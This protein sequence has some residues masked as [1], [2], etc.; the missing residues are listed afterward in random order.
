MWPFTKKP[1]PAPAVLQTPVLDLSR[2]DELAEKPPR[3]GV[4]ASNMPR[5][6]E[7]IQHPGWGLTAQRIRNAF[8]LAE[9][10]YPQ[11]QCDVFA[12]AIERDGKLRSLIRSRI[13]AVG[14]KPWV[15][16]AGGDDPADAAA[17]KSLEQALRR[18]KNTSRTWKHLLTSV[19]Q[20]F[21][22]T[23]IDWDHRDGL[24]VPVHFANV[25]H[26]RFRF[27]P[28]TEEPRLRTADNLID[29]VALTPGKWIFAQ[30]EDQDILRSGLMRTAIWWT[31]LKSLSVRDWQIFCSRFGLPFVIATYSDKG[32]EELIAQLKN[33]VLAF[34]QQGGAVFSEDGKIEVKEPASMSSGNGGGVHPGLVALC[35]SELSILISGATLTSGEGTSAGSYALGQ[36]HQDQ[37]FNLTMDDAEMLAGWFQAEVG[38]PFVRFNGLKARAPRLKMRVVREVNPLTRVQILSICANELGMK[39]DGEQVREENDIKVPTGGETLVGTKKP[40]PPASPQKSAALRAAERARTPEEWTVALDGLRAAFPEVA[41]EIDAAAAK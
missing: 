28:G 22:A 8:V 32:N 12:D 33:A 19:F 17:A 13:S 35:N 4:I 14:G 7:S 39:L 29:G 41:A 23:E 34:G 38:E 30:Q 24:T 11:E 10:G 20:G 40:A 36:V 16:Q 15:L 1:E 2:P 37:S 3:A 9:M 31:W 26:R 6:D 18:V 5:G 27:L 21:A 25:K